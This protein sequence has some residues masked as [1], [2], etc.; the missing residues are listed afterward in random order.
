M[1]S[2]RWYFKCLKI[3]HVNSSHPS[4]SRVFVCL[5][6]G[7]LVQKCI[8]FLEKECVHASNFQ[9]FDDLMQAFARPQCWSACSRWQRLSACG[10]SFWRWSLRVSCLWN[11]KNLGCTG[12]T[13]SCRQRLGK[14]RSRLVSFLGRN[15]LF[16][17]QC[18]T[19]ERLSLLCKEKEGRFYSGQIA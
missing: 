4:S 16:E 19:E 1:F 11:P 10:W 5:S 8:K 6:V 2:V 17:M 12:R 15:C 13:P 18:K 14:E 7:D 9:D 3:V